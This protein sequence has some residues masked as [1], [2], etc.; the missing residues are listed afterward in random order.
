MRSGILL[1]PSDGIALVIF[2]NSLSRVW[3]ST[4]KLRGRME[5]K[6]GDLFYTKN[7]IVDYFNCQRI[8]PASE[9][10]SRVA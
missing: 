8:P 7:N 9:I 10:Q 1:L 2:Y 3:W 4:D 5:T 6:E